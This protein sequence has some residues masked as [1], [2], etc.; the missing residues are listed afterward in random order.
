LAPLS[1]TDDALEPV[2]DEKTVDLHYNFHH[3]AYAAANRAAFYWK[4]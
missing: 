3:K 2:I 1:F 4:S